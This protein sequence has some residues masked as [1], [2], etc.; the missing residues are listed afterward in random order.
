MIEK[1]ITI[2]NKLGLHARPCSMI[3]KTAS[4]FE[5]KFTIIKD[6]TTINGKSILGLMTL[7]ASKGTELKLV[8]EGEDEEFLM[9]EMVELFDSKFGEE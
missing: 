7:A 5:S 3:V 2:A 1:K 4:K 9:E 8:A 6:T